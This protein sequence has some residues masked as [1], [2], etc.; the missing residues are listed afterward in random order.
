[1]IP[2]TNPNANYLAHR[3]A[4]DAALRAVLDGGWYILG[5]QVKAFESA[6]AAWAGC[7]H[8]IGV[9][10]G[11][12]AV[13]LA[14]RACGVQP[15]D[16]VFTV[17][18]TAV[19]TVV[20]IE[21]AGATPVLVDIDPLTFTICPR[22]L[23][24]AINAAREK[25]LGTPK[26]ILAVHLY[27][28]PADLPALAE[29]ADR[30]RLLLIEDCAQAH[31]AVSH[32]RRVGSWGVAAAF[33]FYPTKNLGALGD[34]GLVATSD[35]AIAER[36]RM[37][38][39]YG[40]RQRYVSDAPGL[41]SRLDELQA[42]ILLAKLPHLDADNAA[43]IRLAELYDRLLASA[44]VIRPARREDCQH[45][46]H[47]YVI[48]APRRDALQQQLKN[49]GIGT[50]IHY[51]MPVH[52]QPAY[53]QRLPMLVPLPHTEAAAREVLSLPMFPELDE[54]A[55]RQVAEAIVAFT[56]PG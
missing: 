24:A 42:A 4:I 11:T 16:L 49:V 23:E 1:M 9:A 17:S 41:N 30:Q 56:Q 20:G 22:S 43:R 5:P 52:L 50:L 8:G 44:S 21:R 32:N 46:Y 39:E 53:H 26:A 51:P 15:G 54:N 45:V 2:Q 25:N 7:S 31:G 47:Q 29:L 35:P 10:S 13:E 18:H 19:A 6:F 34:G 38:R 3:H 28:H 37:L 33:S 27:G 48:R 12:D 14:L 40:W 36:C 55:A